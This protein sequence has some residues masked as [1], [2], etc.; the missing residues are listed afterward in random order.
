MS[1]YFEPRDYHFTIELG[2]GPFYSPAM[3]RK[4]SSGFIAIEFFDA[5]PDAGGALVVPT[6]GTLT[7]TATEHEIADATNAAY[8]SLPNGVIDCTNSAYPRPNWVGITT[9]IK[10][11]ETVAVTGN[12]VTHARIKVLR[13]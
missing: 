9:F 3:A 6:A 1:G 13:T 12:G 11:V 5:D 7:I 8:G 2:A 4:L 10:L